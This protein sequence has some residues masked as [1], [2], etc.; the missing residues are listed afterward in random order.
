MSSSNDFL[1]AGCAQVWVVYPRTQT[2][3]VHRNISEA[4]VYTRDEMIDAGDVL[5]EFSCLVSDFFA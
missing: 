2:V 1:S 5:P 3:M 4:H